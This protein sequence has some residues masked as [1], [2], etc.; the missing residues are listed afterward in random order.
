M[1]YAFF[2]KKYFLEHCKQT[3]ASEK[4]MVLTES[5]F[6]AKYQVV[7]TVMIFIFDKVL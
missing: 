3:T 1:V 7:K 2:Q 4:E 6:K 5:C